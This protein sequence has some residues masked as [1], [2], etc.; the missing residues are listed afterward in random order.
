M[1]ILHATAI[2]AFLIGPAYAQTDHVPQYGEKDPDK[3]Q[4][5]IQGEKDTQRAYKRA[6]GNIPD[7]GPTDPWGAVRSTDAPKTDA[8]KTDAHKAPVA[9]SKNKASAAK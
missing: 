9:K 1:R 2:I 7:K 4:T 6:L 8:P 5:Q 3:T